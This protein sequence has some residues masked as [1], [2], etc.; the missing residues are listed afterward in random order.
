MTTKPQ[1][2][3]PSTSTTK[4]LVFHLTLAACLIFWIFVFVDSGWGPDLT[5]LSIQLHS[6]LSIVGLFY[7]IWST[8]YLPGA[9]VGGAML[10]RYGPRRV[11]FVAAL[12][13]L[14][15]MLLILLGVS[16]VS[17]KPLA[18]YIPIAALLVVAGLAGTGG[19]VIDATTNGLISSVYAHRRGSALNLFNLLYPL[20]G[21]IIA[22]I[23]AGLLTLFHN[24]PRP[25]LLFTICFTALAMLSLRGIPRRYLL[26][27]PTLSIETVV[28]EPRE[29]RSLLAIL[30]PVIIVMMLTSGISSSTR[31]WTPAYLH[32]AYGQTPAIAAALSSVSWMLAAS[33]RLGASILILRIGAWRMVMLGVIVSLLGLIGMAF[34]PNALLATLAIALTSI[35]LSPIFATCLAIGSERA[36]R[37]PGAVAGILLF[38]SGISTVLCSWLFGFLLNGPGPLWAVGFC[39]V[40]MVM[41]G[42]L[43]LRL[44]G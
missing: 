20:G 26:E 34:S 37:S 6:P 13:I 7:V 24:D 1:P 32:V 12:I 42:V 33:S 23:D 43:A 28:E 29:A 31:A 39:F 22:L 19:G 17:W 21:V 5:P 41:G 36:G 3:T 40:C 35:G 18:S 4:T 16:A 44:R 8:G 15:G 38:A 14:C 10:D 9:L 2:A 30:T 11:L 25:P 27:A